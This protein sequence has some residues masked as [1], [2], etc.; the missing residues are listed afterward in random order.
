MGVGVGV[1]GST[2]AASC[3]VLKLVKKQ[4]GEETN[5]QRQPRQPLW[6]PLLVSVVSLP[7]MIVVMIVAVRASLHSTWRS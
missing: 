7:Y 6:Q 1:S 3:G 2:A 4:H 5:Y